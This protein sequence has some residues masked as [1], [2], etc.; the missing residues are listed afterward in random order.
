MK[1]FEKLLIDSVKFLFDE[2]PTLSTLP[3][4]AWGRYFKYELSGESFDISYEN[5]FEYLAK[6]QE[7]LKKHIFDM[8]LLRIIDK[9]LSNFKDNEIQLKFEDINVPTR[10]Q[11]VN[12]YNF[13]DR[14]GMLLIVVKEDGKFQIRTESCDS[15]E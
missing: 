8:D 4:F 2:Y 9:R 13:D 7:Y 5:G 11:C 10:K 6:L 12:A 14:A 15:P 3:V 1:K